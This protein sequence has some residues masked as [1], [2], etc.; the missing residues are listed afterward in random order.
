MHCGLKDRPVVGIKYCAF[1][2]E[3]NA[4]EAST[5]GSMVCLV[6]GLQAGRLGLFPRL[7][8]ARLIVKDLS[9]WTPWKL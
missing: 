8:D 9:M 1:A 6:L 2:R 7:L 3:S 4:N 5:I